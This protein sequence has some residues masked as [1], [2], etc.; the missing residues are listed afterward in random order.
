MKKDLLVS[1]VIPFY[2]GREFIKETLESFSNQT[3]QHWECLVIDDYSEE[4][5]EDICESL[6]DSRIKYV[7]NDGS[8]GMANARNKGCSIA[9]GEFIALSDQDDISLPNRLMRQVETLQEDEELL[10]VGTWRRN[11]GGN[12]HE[13]HYVTDPEEIKI[14]LLGNSQFTNPS[15]MFRSSLFY[16]KGV[17]FDQKM[18]PVDD[19]DFFCKVSL[20]GKL[21]N[22]PE[23]LFLYRIH[24]K[25][26][27][28]HKSNEMEKLA[29][30]IREIY[31]DKLLSNWITF[32]LNTNDMVD[33]F[34]MNQKLNVSPKEID[35]LFIFLTELNERS[36]I[37]TKKYWNAFLGERFL[38]VVKYL[39]ISVKIKLGMVFQ[40]RKLVK[41]FLQSRELK[42][43]MKFLLKSIK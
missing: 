24:D 22:I 6:N 2:N 31:T 28:L 33:I 20:L 9:K 5:V 16:N 21:T 29:Y 39:D 43:G 41:A 36:P 7:K 1:I 40:H 37:W 17:K 13:A 35:T 3:Y 14:R 25:Q 8:R 12:D 4:L 15:I 11:F 42:N 19:Y 10:L 23:V 30:N 34:S 18:A 26:V 38:M 27:S 32:G